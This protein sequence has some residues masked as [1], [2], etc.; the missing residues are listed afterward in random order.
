MSSPLELFRRL[1][2]GV[3]VVGVSHAGKRDA[4]TAAWITQV[5]FDPLLLMLS[6]NPEHYSYPLLT[7]ARGFAVT[8]LGEG[9]LDLVRHFGTQSGR[10]LDKLAGQPWK[11]SAS[12]FPV[13]T[14]GIAWM[15]C[16]LD[17]LHFSGDHVLALAR[18]TGGEV[19]D[20]RATPLLYRDT[21]NI[22]GSAALFPPSFPVA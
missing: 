16:A 20:P 12:G 21:G 4:F 9:Q 11:E 22:D 10:D 2:N 19:L 5:S 6:I 15:D 3:H 8:I 14:T 13:I 18:V 1:T 17:A 7:G